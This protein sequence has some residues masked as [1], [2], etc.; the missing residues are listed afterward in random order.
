LK[1]RGLYQGTL[2][3]IAADHG[4][5]FGEHGEQRHGIFLYDETIHVPLLF[6]LPG[7]ESAG[8][9]VENRVAL[10]DVAPTVLRLA[11]LPIPAAMQG[12]SLADRIK[13]PTATNKLASDKIPERAIYSETDYPR[14]AFGWSTLR[15]WRAGK[16]LYVQAPRRELYDQSVDPKALHNLAP[17]SKAVADTVEAQLDA[18]HNKTSSAQTEQPKLD[19]A[20][21]EDLRSLGYLASDA[22][23]SNTNSKVAGTDPKDKIEIANLLHQAL[24]DMEEDRYED[25][26]PRLER[27]IR[28]EPSASTAFLELGRALVH[29][30]NY[31]KALPVL[32]QAVEKMPESGI[33]HYELGLAMVKMGQWESAL[34]EFQAAVVVTPASAQLH[35]YL[36]AV[37]ARLKRVP[38]AAKEFETS[39]QQDPDHYQANLVYGHMLVLEGEPAAALPK[40]RKAAKLQPDSGE[41]HRY[42]ADAYAQLGQEGIAQRECLLAERLGPPVRPEKLAPV[43]ASETP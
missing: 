4:E 5:A 37:F 32:R 33:A 30:K 6:K 24:V 38:E 18:F 14:R 15:S 3:A 23:R 13:A 26:I 36:G 22:G 27:V 8:R 12:Q 9:R 1:T 10:A 19:P 17:E 7:G 20:Q 11:G 29:L 43:F 34:P 42:L 28:D 39:L 16:Y 2:I 40:L 41:P 21:A 25:A 31:E 35:F